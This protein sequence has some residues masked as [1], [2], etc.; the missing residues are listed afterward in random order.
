MPGSSN[1]NS[2]YNYHSLDRCAQIQVPHSS[3]S[4][5]KESQ[6]PEDSSFSTDIFNKVG[7]TNY[8][9]NKSH[10]GTDLDLNHGNK[11]N[12]HILNNFRGFGLKPS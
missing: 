3:V 1:T 6:Q 9:Q 10:L 2:A 5:E 8:T 12:H 4:Q 7:Y 11:L